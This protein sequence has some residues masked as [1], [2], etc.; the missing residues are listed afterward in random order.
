MRNKLLWTGLAL[1]F[2]ATGAL[3]GIICLTACRGLMRGRERSQPKR[4]SGAS[5]KMI[6]AAPNRIAQNIVA[7]A[8]KL[9]LGYGVL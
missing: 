9:K 2:L 7:M 5:K 6:D 4:R 8:E 1:C 3:G